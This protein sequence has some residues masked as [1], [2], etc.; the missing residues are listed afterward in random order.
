MYDIFD[1]ALAS[2]L[3]D[4][5]ELAAGRPRGEEWIVVGP[6]DG[7]DAFQS[8][9]DIEFDSTQGF[10]PCR[11]S[12]PRPPPPKPHYD[13]IR[14]HSNPVPQIKQLRPST[15]TE[16]FLFGVLTA[17]PVAVWQVRYSKSH[18]PVTSW[19][20]FPLFGP[21]WSRVV[22]T[23]PKSQIRTKINLT[24]PF[25]AWHKFSAVNPHGPLCQLYVLIGV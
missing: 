5:C 25:L 17:L 13:M 24:S 18:Q 12:F 1:W 22:G 3:M 23:F 11:R 6:T 19:P 7:R 4:G 21:M 10:L 15:N 8:L 2:M 14:A 16:Y 9:C 20:G